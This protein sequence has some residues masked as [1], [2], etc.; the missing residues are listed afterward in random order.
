MPHI[1]AA[2]HM[3]WSAY[4]ISL[5]SHLSTWGCVAPATLVC[6]ARLATAEQ[7]L[8]AEVAAVVAGRSAAENNAK[9]F[10]TLT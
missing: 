9:S 5:P 8:V 7:T 4:H 2:D 6:R 3:A 1:S 10:N